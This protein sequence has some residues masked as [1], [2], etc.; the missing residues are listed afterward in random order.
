MKEIN[1]EDAY[2]SIIERLQNQDDGVTK[3]EEFKN[4]L[5]GI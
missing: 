5:E 2:E 1:K 3:A 4:I